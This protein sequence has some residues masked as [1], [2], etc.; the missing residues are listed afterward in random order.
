MDCSSAQPPE[1][2]GSAPGLSSA[3]SRRRPSF[4]RRAGAWRRPC[5]AQP[6]ESTRR[7]LGDV[8]DTP[9]YGAFV[10]LKRAGSSARAAA[11][12][13][14]RCRCARRLDHAADRAATDDPR[15]PPIASVELSQLD[16]DVWIL[17]GPEPVTARGEDRV[18]AVAIGKHG[19]QMPAARPADCCCRAWRSSIISTRGP[20][21]NRC[22]SRPACPP[23]PGRTTTRRCWSSRAMRSTAGCEP[24]RSRT[25]GRPRWPAGSIRAMPREVRADGRKLFAAGGAGRRRSLAGGA[26]AARRLDLLGPAGGGRLQPRGD[27]RSR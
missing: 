20:F 25:F 12:R 15:F 3:R 1:P 26:G 27:S 4:G 21:C 14:R 22:A 23:T 13:A 18:Q 2:S 19:V 6:A 9:V 8:A 5:D 11:H 17:W 24:E 7:L 16:M 10:T